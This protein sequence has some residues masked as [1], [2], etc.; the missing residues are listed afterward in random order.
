MRIVRRQVRLA[1]ERIAGIVQKG[2]GGGLRHAAFRSTP[3]NLP[4]AFTADVTK[5]HA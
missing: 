1:G 4:S 2:D 3:L 5:F